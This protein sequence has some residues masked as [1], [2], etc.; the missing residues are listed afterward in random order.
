MSALLKKKMMAT[1]LPL[2]K[3]NNNAPLVIILCNISLCSPESLCRYDIPTLESWLCD[4]SNSACPGWLRCVTPHSFVVCIL[5]T[6]L[7]CS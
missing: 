5:F 4:V 3:K 6:P 7:S 2:K 1:P